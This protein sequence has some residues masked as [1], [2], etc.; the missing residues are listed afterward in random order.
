M[1]KKSILYL[2]VGCQIL[3]VYAADDFALS[4]RK[5]SHL[6][7][8]IE[9]RNQ[10]QVRSNNAAPQDSSIILP[11]YISSYTGPLVRSSSRI[12]LS[13]QACSTYHCPTGMDAAGNCYRQSLSRAPEE[14]YPHLPV[15]P[16][17]EILLSHPWRQGRVSHWA[18]SAPHSIQDH[19]YRPGFFSGSFYGDSASCLSCCSP[20]DNPEAIQEF[21]T[22]GSRAYLS[23]S[24]SLLSQGGQSNTLKLAASNSTGGQATLRSSTAKHPGLVPLC[25]PPFPSSSRENSQAIYAG[26]GGEEEEGSEYR[27]L[28]Q[29]LFAPLENSSAF[30][31][32]L[33][34]AAS[35]Y[36]DNP[37]AK[38]QCFRDNGS[39]W[40]DSRG[41][42]EQQ[43]QTE[44]PYQSS[45]L[46]VP[47]E[48]KI[49][50]EMR[51]ASSLHTS[52]PLSHSVGADAPQFPP[53]LPHRLQGNT[54]I[55]SQVFMET[56]LVPAE[57]YSQAA[58]RGEPVKQRSNSSVRSAYEA[59]PS[60]STLTKSNTVANLLASLNNQF[61]ED[62]EM[63]HPLKELE[64]YI[65]V[66]D[67][68]TTIRML[69]DAYEIA[70]SL[71]RI[72]LYV[73][74][75][76]EPLPSWADPLGNVDRKRLSSEFLGYIDLLKRRHDLL[77][78]RQKIGKILRDIEKLKSDCQ[79]LDYDLGGALDPLMHQVNAEKQELDHINGIIIQFKRQ[80]KFPD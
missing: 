36:P 67:D 30:Q 29:E 69:I 63:L 59:M 31:A 60:A 25:M 62:E 34:P 44:N 19:L 47:D 51:A 77:P 24:L 28:A 41:E 9:V 78:R 74:Y 70:E 2:L 48:L 40:E 52:P 6:R 14:S 75:I 12:P 5:N 57:E 80:K 56:A 8:K 55:S 71:G 61:Q 1:I 49:T 26:W 27:A 65:R 35:Q 13:S 58:E 22:V 18:P 42:K 33:L 4:V 15:Q 11:S 45:L 37:P 16:S 53:R 46:W 76:L 3:C 20:G 38:K 21:T 10:G 50:P 64:A 43:L 39:V 68:S 54:L 7:R 66:N 79:N 32:A 17:T 73:K 23:S 72:R